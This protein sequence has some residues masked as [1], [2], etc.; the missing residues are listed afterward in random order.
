MLLVD[1][2]VD[3]IFINFFG[4]SRKA[5]TL[6]LQSQTSHHTIILPQMVLSISHTHLPALFSTTHENRPYWSGEDESNLQNLFS[7]L[8]YTLARPL[9]NARTVRRSSLEKNISQTTSGERLLFCCKISARKAN[10]L[11]PKCALLSPQFLI[12]YVFVFFLAA[13]CAG[14]PGTGP[15]LR[16]HFYLRVLLFVHKIVCFRC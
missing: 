7:Q 13:V 16:S 4:P 9:T 2:R 14:S 6:S 12:H 15:L 5:V 1:E 10:S 3:S 8:D 11:P